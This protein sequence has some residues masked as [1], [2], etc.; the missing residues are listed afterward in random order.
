MCGCGNPVFEQGIDSTPFLFCGENIINIRIMKKRKLYVK[1]FVLLG[2]V[3]T[4]LVLTENVETRSVSRQRF[5]ISDPVR[6][7]V[8]AAVEECL[9]AGINVRSI[10][11]GK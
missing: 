10:L 8:P 5:A 4:D 2:L 3:N 1:L 11:L 7:D 9:K 6:E